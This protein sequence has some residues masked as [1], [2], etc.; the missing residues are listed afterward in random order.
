MLA[1]AGSAGAA[2]FPSLRFADFLRQ[3]DDLLAIRPI[4]GQR[5]SGFGAV[6]E[7]H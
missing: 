2:L 3:L 4:E 7:N 1:D 6:S 5:C